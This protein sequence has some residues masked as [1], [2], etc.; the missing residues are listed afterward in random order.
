[1]PV[2]EQVVLAH[3]QPHAELGQYRVLV[4]VVAIERRRRQAR[5]FADQVGGQP[6]D[7]DLAQQV[8]RGVEDALAGLQRTRLRRRPLSIELHAG[9]G[10]RRRVGGGVGFSRHG[11]VGGRSGGSVSTV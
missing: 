2:L 10:G 3:H 7:A 5:A 6:L 4:R 1:G 11:V 9:G 8:G